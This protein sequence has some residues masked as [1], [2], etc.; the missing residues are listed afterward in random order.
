VIDR[1]AFLPSLSAAR[2]AAVLTVVL[3]SSPF[4]ADAQPRRIYR[5]GVLEGFATAEARTYRAVF[6]DAMLELG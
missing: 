5:V 3:L 1:R 6:F 4:A 2:V